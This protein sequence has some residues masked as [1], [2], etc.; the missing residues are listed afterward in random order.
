MS[1][2]ETPNTSLIRIAFSAYADSIIDSQLSYEEDEE[3]TD[4]NDEVSK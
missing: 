2:S 3:T 1:S 4:E